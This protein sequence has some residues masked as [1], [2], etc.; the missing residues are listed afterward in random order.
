M[1]HERAMS[2]VASLSVRDVVDSRSPSRDT[3]SGPKATILEAHVALGGGAWLGER[4]TTFVVWA[5]LSC[6]F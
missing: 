1:M 5:V 4:L 3:S 2:D 6:Q